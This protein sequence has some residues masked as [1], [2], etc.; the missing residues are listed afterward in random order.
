M[1][2]FIRLVCL[3]LLAYQYPHKISAQAYPGFTNS[4]IHRQKALERRKVDLA[5]GVYAIIGYSLSNFGVIISKTGY[6]LIDVGS[7]P[8]EVKKALAEI[9]EVIPGTLRAIILTHSHVDHRSGA[10]EILKEQGGKVPVYGHVDF[11]EEE[12]SV[13]GLE[14]ITAQRS[15]K[16]FGQGIPDNE[17]TVNMM[18]PRFP[19]SKMGT[20]ISPDHFVQQGKTEL[21]I[22]GVRLELYTLPSETKDHLAI[23]MPD[24][25]VLFSGDAVY[26]C[27][28]NIYPIRGGVYRDVEQ[29]IKTIHRL[30]EFKPDAIMFGHLDA[31][32][33]D[34]NIM[35]VLDNSAKAIEYVYNETIKGMDEGKT[36]NELAAQI[37]LPP[38][39]R[40]L[41]YLGEQYEAIPW[42]VREIY[43]A[44]LGWFDGNPTNLVPLTPQEEAERM[45]SLVGGKEQLLL[46]TRK[47]LKKGDFRW[48]AQ[49]S[50]MLLLLG[51]EAEGRRIKA[52]ALKGIS[53]MILPIS[54]KNYLL[55][56]ALDLRNN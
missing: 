20:P 6:I 37:Q 33:G 19:G 44:K 8:G 25:K 16:Q 30:M 39:L 56:S 27:F 45:A 35:P 11:G 48:A 55:R 14:K 32:V 53:R 3:S 36:P 13:K 1:N 28:P 54:G 24:R 31:I 12:R 42:V 51:E 15:A 43:A 52:D 7:H 9:K 49:L 23:W 5:P 40:E 50:D 21:I 47:A 17:Y 2:Q 4:P 41:P 10:D 22:D 26:D 38:E 29:W 34:T 18:L 46:V